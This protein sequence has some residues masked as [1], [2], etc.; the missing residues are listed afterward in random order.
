MNEGYISSVP[1]MLY[2]PSAPAFSSDSAQTQSTQFAQATQSMP[3]LLQYVTTAAS[4]GTKTENETCTS[5]TV[6]ITAT[7]T[8]A[9]NSTLISSAEQGSIAVGVAGSASTSEPNSAF[10]T[11]I[12]SAAMQTDVVTYGALSALSSPASNLSTAKL[13]ASAFTTRSSS[14]TGALGGSNNNNSTATSDA[15]AEDAA[16]IS[17]TAAGLALGIMLLAIL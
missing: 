4:S 10:N 11:T 13:P 16:V 1:F 2:S 5:L 7:G 17:Y 9:G 8:V 3:T 15:K 6:Y 14:T 12:T